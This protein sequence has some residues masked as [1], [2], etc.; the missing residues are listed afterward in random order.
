MIDSTVGDAR[1]AAAIAQNNRD[2]VQAFKLDRF[3]LLNDIASRLFD[4]PARHITHLVFDFDRTVGE[5]GL[6][7]ASDWLLQQFTA[8]VTVTGALPPTPGPLLI[9]SNHPGLVDAMMIF[10]QL[11]ERPLRV[12]AADRPILHLLPHTTD[13]LIFIPDEPERRLTAI[14]AAAAH[15]R[16]DGVL[17][18]FPGGHIEPDPAL[19]VDAAESLR[20]WSDSIALFGRL[21]PDLRVL[22]VAA[23]GVIS[24]RALRHPITRLYRTAERREWVAAT[25]QVMLP[26]YRDTHVTLRIGTS[27][28][29]TE[30]LMTDVRAQMATLLV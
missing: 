19:H 4:L 23:R 26:R 15:L 30:S 29:P 6:A 27:I 8:L 21:V 24:P 22:P 13:Y 25:L 20:H 5:R 14:R 3:G 7:A 12:L 9:V 17:V 11:R 2:M 10:A 16:K 1:L 18:T 28:V